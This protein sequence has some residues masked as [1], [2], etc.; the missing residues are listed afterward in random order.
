MP[1]AY[2]SLSCACSSIQGLIIQ[3]AQA[4]TKWRPHNLLADPIRRPS[5]ATCCHRPVRLA[6]IYSLTAGEALRD[7][8]TICGYSKTCRMCFM[9]AVSP[10]K[11]EDFGA[12]LVQEPAQRPAPLPADPRGPGKALLSV[13]GES[14]WKRPW[15]PRQ[16][17]GLRPSG[18][19]PKSPRAAA[20]FLRRPR[21]YMSR[22]SGRRDRPS[23]AMP[24]TEPRFRRGE[25]WWRA[26]T[27]IRAQRSRGESP[28]RWWD[29]GG[30]AF[31]RRARATIGAVVP[32]QPE[33]APAVPKPPC[34]VRRCP[35]VYRLLRTV[36]AMAETDPRAQGG[37]IADTNR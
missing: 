36:Y 37:V 6:L 16:G 29:P 8:L 20:D 32:L 30:S 18:P 17:A 19:A 15:R 27:R 3:P 1:Q 34:R 11:C 4:I 26:S 5:I 14:A 23:W 13:G 2:R 33:H 9:G 25:I 24:I 21:T 7:V 10:K 28:V 35:P 12:K 22:G 31:R